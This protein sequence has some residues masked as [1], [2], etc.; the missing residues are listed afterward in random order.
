M[1]E[2]NP[3]LNLKQKLKLKIQ[4]VGKEREVGASCDYAEKGVEQCREKSEGLLGRQESQLIL[5]HNNVRLKTIKTALLRGNPS[6]VFVSMLLVFMF[7][8]LK[9]WF[10]V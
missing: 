5:K 8:S 2:D 10:L 9:K 4:S 1:N 6:L 7:L 3:I